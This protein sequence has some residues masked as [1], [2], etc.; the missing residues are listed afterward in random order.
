MS[1]RRRPSADVVVAGHLC[2]DLRPALESTPAVTQGRITAVGELDIRPGG[3]VANTGS[4]LAALGSSVRLSGLVGNDP[5]GRVVV[6]WAR[7]IDGLDTSGITVTED[8]STSYSVIVQPRGRDR[9]IWHYTG[10]NDLFDG[11]GV[12]LDREVL[13]HIGYPPLLP[14]MYARDGALLIDVMRSASGVGATTSLDMATPDLQSDAGTIDWRRMLERTLPYVDIAVPSLD[15]LRTM[16]ARE[17]ASLEDIRA[18]ARELIDMGAAIVLLTDGPNGTYLATAGEDRVRAGGSALAPLPPEWHGR[19]LW[20][21]RVETT[22]AGTTGAG[23][24]A[25][26]G[27]LHAILTRRGPA[28]A[29]RLA[30]A[31]AAVRIGGRPIP[32]SD[33][34]ENRLDSSG[35]FARPDDNDWPE[36]LPGVLLGP[37]DRTGSGR[38]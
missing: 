5:L 34:L 31:A 38:R 26:A 20:G 16:L 21:C 33:V 22:V 23:D 6:D 2:V 17:L 37:A 24:A 27:L 10:A 35:S 15:D 32:P 25:A 12:E 36:E 28:R 1:A 9:A 14:A 8:A 11:R 4:T 18:V 19:E 30:N 3:C 13:V 7:S 29:L